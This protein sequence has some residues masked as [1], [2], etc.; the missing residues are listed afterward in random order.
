MEY[1]NYTREQ[2]LDL[3]AYG[4]KAAKEMTAR[5]NHVAAAAVTKNVCDMMD[6]LY[7]RDASIAL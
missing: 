5:D 6:E 2:L 3:V 1:T 4:L 7:T